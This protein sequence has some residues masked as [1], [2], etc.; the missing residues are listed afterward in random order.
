MRTQITTRIEY[1]IEPDQDPLNPRTEWDNVGHMVCWHSRYNLGD[2]QPSED[3]TEYLDNLAGLD[4]IKARVDD[5][6][7]H[8]WDRHDWHGLETRLTNYLDKIRAKALDDYIILPLYLYD[9]SGITM[10]CSPF[11]CP[12]DSGQVGFIYMSIDRAR[13]EWTGTDDEIREAATKCLIAEVEEYDQYLTGDVWG[14]TIDRVT[15][16]E[17]GDESD[18][19]ELESCWGFFG[20]SYCEDEARLI[21]NGYEDHKE[22]A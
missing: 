18:R 6:V 14:Y 20:H 5:V 15:L 17:D 16:D 9:H 2:E 10:G 4:D 1:T 3:P 8:F 21:V 12:W 19:E 13:K 7:N 11:S 22:A